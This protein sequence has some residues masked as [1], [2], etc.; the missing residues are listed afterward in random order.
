MGYA[1]HQL[2][3]LGLEAGAWHDVHVPGRGTSGVLSG[4]VVVGVIVIKIID[5]LEH[6]AC[7]IEQ[8]IGTAAG[9]IVAH[10]AGM[11]EAAT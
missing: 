3:G 9:G 10:G 5:P 6:V 2:G 8:A 7:H 11:T 1:G 4:H